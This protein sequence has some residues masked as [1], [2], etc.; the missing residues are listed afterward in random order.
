MKGFL[1][2]VICLIAAVMFSLFWRNYCES[3]RNKIVRTGVYDHVEYGCSGKGASILW[4][5]DG[6]NVVCDWAIT[7][8]FPKGTLVSMTRG[9]RIEEIK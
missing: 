8:P 7:M 9:C 2:F 1:A 4:F 6:S 5:E 3:C